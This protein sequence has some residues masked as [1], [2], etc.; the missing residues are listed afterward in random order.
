[1]LALVNMVDKKAYNDKI[2]I[3]TKTILWRIKRLNKELEKSPGKKLAI[4]QGLHNIKIYELI[5]KIK[6]LRAKRLF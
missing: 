3:K 6:Q 4:H 1:M 5:T 2:N